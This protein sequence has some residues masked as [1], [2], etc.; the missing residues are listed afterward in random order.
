MIIFRKSN[1][2]K[3]P[4]YISFYYDKKYGYIIFKSG[5]KIKAF[6]L[7]DFFFL[8]A[9]KNKLFVDCNKQ[10]IFKTS[11]IFQKKLFNYVKSTIFEINQFLLTVELKIYKKLILVGIG[12]KVTFFK[13]YLSNVFLFKLGYSHSIFLRQN[14]FVSGFCLG[15]T[16]IFITSNFVA[17]I[18]A[19]CFFIKSLKNINLFTGKGIFFYN[20][21]CN[22]KK[23]KKSRL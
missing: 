4:S 16:K 10:S 9:F 3:I 20:E 18:D 17:Q 23:I 2:I 7:G 1:L 5:Q 13:N 6:M 14:R 15:L 11:Q 8:L 22:L 19:N 21:K 12:F